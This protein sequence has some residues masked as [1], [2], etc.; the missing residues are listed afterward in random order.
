MEAQ[1]S[2]PDDVCNL[3]KKIS[4][5]RDRSEWPLYVGQIKVIEIRRQQFPDG[6]HCP[7]KYGRFDL[8]FS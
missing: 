8:R 2:N 6:F 4:F 1:A 3:Y 5:P 7:C